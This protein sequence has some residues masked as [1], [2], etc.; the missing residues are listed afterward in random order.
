MYPIKVQE[1]KIMT[2]NGRCRKGI[3]EVQKEN[4]ETE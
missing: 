2:I 3:V 4:R 1:L